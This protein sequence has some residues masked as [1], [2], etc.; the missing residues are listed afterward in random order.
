MTHTHTEHTHLL[1]DLVVGG[2]HETLQVLEERVLVLLQKA[3]H[4]VH[5]VAGK[6]LEAE[7]RVALEF[8]VFVVRLPAAVVVV[9][10]KLLVH[11]LQEC[12]V[13]AAP[14]LKSAVGGG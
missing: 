9:A 12:L 11:L 2:V 13:C 3:L 6:V 5:D 7:L 14:N 10:G 4:L 8:L 1:D